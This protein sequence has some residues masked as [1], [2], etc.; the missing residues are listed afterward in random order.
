MKKTFTL[1]AIAFAI[2]TSAAQAEVRINGFANFVGG[3]TSSDTALYGYDSDFSFKNESLFAVQVTGD[4]NN[5]MT[6]TGQLVARGNDDYSAGFEWAYLT[7]AATDNLSIS[8]GRL[9]LPLFI[10]SSSL[11]VGYSYNW[12]SA[13]KSVYDVPFNNLDGVRF[14][15]SNYVDDFEYS[16]QLAVGTYENDTEAFKIKGDNTVVLS[17]EGLYGIVKIRAVYGRSTST[18]NAYAL[19]STFNQLQQTLPPALYSNLDFNEDTGEFKGLGV[20]VNNGSWYL[21]SEVTSVEIEDS[22]LRKDFSYYITAGM[23]FDKL[24]TSITYEAIESDDD[25]KFIDPISQMPAELQSSLFGIQTLF[26]DDSEAITIGIRYDFDTNI[27][28]KLDGTNYK[29]NLNTVNDAELVRF[30]VNYIF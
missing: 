22:Y 1:S 2:A 27:A 9:R 26:D 12:I 17:A 29:D 23:R 25:F 28:F 18:F 5:K 13:P 4:I 20:E 11:D 21:I 8:A 6:A 16:I 10:Y 3:I 7:Y 30:A 15:Y 24:T 19:E 14:D